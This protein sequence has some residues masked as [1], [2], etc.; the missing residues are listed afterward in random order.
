MKEGTWDSPRASV[1]RRTKEQSTGVK[2]GNQ[3]PHLTA[4]EE[5]LG[6]RN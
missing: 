3:G 2:Y 1:D 4:Q 5:M 6:G